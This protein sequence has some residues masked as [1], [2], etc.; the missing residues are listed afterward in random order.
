MNKNGDKPIEAGLTVS[1]AVAP[2]VS[3]VQALTGTL[4]SDKNDLIRDVGHLV[5]RGIQGRLATGLG[6]TYND[7]KSR[8]KI[9]ADYETTDQFRQ[10]ASY[11]FGAISSDGAIDEERFDAMKNIFLNSAQERISGRDDSIP[12]ELMRVCN[13]LNMGE[14]LVL[15]AASRLNENAMQQ[16]ASGESHTL[17]YEPGIETSWFELIAKESGMG[18]TDMVI[19]YEESLVAKRLFNKRTGGGMIVADTNYH[20]SGMGLK[21]CEFIKTYEQ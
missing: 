9:K 17:G 10:E 5:Q 4:T 12:V 8:G 11:V 18:V 21:L 19:P 7:L 20:L 15:E 14:I 13:T 1:P 6:E 2:L 3:L 16:I